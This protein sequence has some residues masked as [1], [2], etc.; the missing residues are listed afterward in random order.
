MADRRAGPGGTGPVIGGT[1]PTGHPQTPIVD[2]PL[3]PP[4]I[5]P[6]TFRQIEMLNEAV[7]NVFAAD[8]PT[9]KP[10]A[11]NTLRWDVTMPTTVIPGVVPVLE[12]SVGPNGRVDGLSA[13][14][15]RPAKQ[16]SATTYALSII[17]PKASRWLGSLTIDVDLSEARQYGLVAFGVTTKVTERLTAG[18]PDG[19]A[20]TLR[21]PPKVGMHLEAVTVDLALAVDVPHFFDAEA[22]V[23]VSWTLSGHGPGSGDPIDADAQIACSISTA[24]TNVDPGTLGSIFS[25]GCA[26]VAAAAVEKVSDGYLGQLVGPLIAEDIREQL[27][28]VAEDRRPDEPGW[29]FH[30]LDVTPD[31][32]TFWYCTKP[33]PTSQPGTGTHPPVHPTNSG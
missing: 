12:L 7:L 15:S 9:A 18:F 20:L 31:G 32:L 1:D 22:D 5:D 25:G 3:P 30:H 11:V 17:A 29:I 4:P 2:P 33:A 16:R 10:F 6:D 23:S 26:D 19:G 27:T 28:G 24:H 8:L 21:K 13:A 14:G